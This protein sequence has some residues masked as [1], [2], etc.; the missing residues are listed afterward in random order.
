MKDQTWWGI[1]DGPYT[2]PG[3]EEKELRFDGRARCIQPVQLDGVTWCVETFWA[4]HGG[5]FEPVEMRIWSYSPD[6]LAVQ[7]DT[8]RRLPLGSLQR[9]ARRSAV[10]KA[11]I[12]RAKGSLAKSLGAMASQMSAYEEIAG[13]YDR[14]AAPGPHRGAAAGQD[15]L[16][17]IAAV[18]MKAWG[19][20]WPGV[21]VAVADHFNIAKSTA[22]KRIM[23]AR[24]A[25]LLDKAK[26][27]R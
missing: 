22:A 24:R 9:E 4:D 11:S 8:V 19:K 23:K 14:L 15:E 2:R 25:G 27:I 7:A 3:H 12:W 17:E 20:G 10:D 21:T 5:R 13:R 6:G 18:Y 1:S 16:E 26:R